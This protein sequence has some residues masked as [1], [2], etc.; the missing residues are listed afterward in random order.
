MKLII[1]NP[2]CSM[3][4]V[5]VKVRTYLGTTHAPGHCES[6]DVS[7]YSGKPSVFILKGKTACEMLIA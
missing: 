3:V 6:E 2:I 4:Q 7:W 1:N 5:I